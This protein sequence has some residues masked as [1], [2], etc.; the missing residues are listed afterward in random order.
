VKKL[1][2]SSFCGMIDGY[3]DMYIQRKRLN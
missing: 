3:K 2:K 1:T